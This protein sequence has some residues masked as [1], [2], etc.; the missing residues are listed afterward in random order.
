MVPIIGSKL[1]LNLGISLFSVALLFQLI[2][3]P[4]EFNA[5]SRALKSLAKNN[6][7]TPEELKGTKSVLCAAALTYVAATFNSL[8]YL[9]RLI[10][11][12][13]SRD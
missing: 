11:I 6:I 2:T 4:V 5:S 9:L 13:R 1:F 8:L 3:L 10:F 7:L 12:S